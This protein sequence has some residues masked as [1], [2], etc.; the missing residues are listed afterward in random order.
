MKVAE[1]EVRSSL[2]AIYDLPDAPPGVE[3]L[4]GLTFL[5]QFEVRLDSA[6]NQLHLGKIG[7]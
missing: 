5:R 1:A 7:R 4:L 2:A 6:H 3:G